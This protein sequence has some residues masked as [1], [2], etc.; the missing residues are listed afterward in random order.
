MLRAPFVMRPAETVAP[1]PEGMEMTVA[2][3]TVPM[4]RPIVCLIAEHSFI[5]L[6]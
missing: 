5:S 1:T 2:V 3:V 4:V 6:S